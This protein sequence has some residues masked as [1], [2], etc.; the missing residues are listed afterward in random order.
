MKMRP[1]TEL[2][3]ALILLLT[4]SN[5]KM[6]SYNENGVPYTLGIWTVKPGMG[7]E[8]IR[9]WTSF[10]EWTNKNISGSGKAYLLQDEKNPLRFISFGPWADER[11]IQKWRDS[12]EFK[13]F[14]I[15]AKELCDDFQPNTLKVVS[16]SN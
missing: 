1:I 7:E 3:T 13:E 9:E 6:E 5:C 14:V 15:K 2:W 4:L 10:A 12:S 11:T 8:F 16:T